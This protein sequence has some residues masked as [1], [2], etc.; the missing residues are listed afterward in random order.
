ML[1]KQTTH[2]ELLF[3]PYRHRGRKAAQA[4]GREGVIRLEQPLEFQEWL[5]VEGDRAQLVERDP[6]LLEHE[7]AGMNRKRRIVPAS[8]EALLLRRRD[9]PAVD[10]QR[11]GA[12]AVVGGDAENR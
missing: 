5:V 11:R 12:I 9:D 10:E 3:D 7:A 4:G 2:E 8:R 6:R 1:L